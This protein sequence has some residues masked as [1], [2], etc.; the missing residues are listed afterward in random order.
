MGLRELLRRNAPRAALALLLLAGTAEATPPCHAIAEPMG[1]YNMRLPGPGSV[2]MTTTVNLKRSMELAGQHMLG[3]LCPTRNYLPYWS[4][5]IDGNYRAQLWDYW[6]N[7]NLGRW[8]DA[9]LR[10]EDATG[11]SIPAH[12][13]KAMLDNLRLF[14]ENPDHFCLCPLDMKQYKDSF[15][16]LHSL[17]E[18]LLALTALVRYRKSEWAK[19]K[20]HSMIETLLRVTREDGSLCMEKIDRAVRTNNEGATYPIG[21]SL[22]R[23]VEALVWFHK[24]TGD[25]LALLAAR[26]FARYHLDHATHSDGTL[27]R[28]TTGG[29]THSYLGTIRGLLLYGELT[30]QRRYVDRVAATYVTTVRSLVKKSGYTSHDLGRERRGETASPGDAAQLALWLATRHGYTEFYDDVERIVRARIIPSQIT[31]S[32]PLRP[33]ADNDEDENRNLTERVIGA[34]GGMHGAPHWGKRPVLDVTTADLHTLAD[35]YNNIA[36]R[37]DTGLRINFHFDYE[38]DNVRVASERGK[39]ARVTIVPK[40]E[41]N[42]FVRIPGWAPRRSVRLSLNGKPAKLIMVGVFAVVSGELRDGSI[43]VKYELPVSTETER[44]ND[45]D[46]K[47]VWRGDEVIGIRPNSEFYPFYPTYVSAEK[48]K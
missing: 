12:I 29:H 48:A 18:G 15:F 39:S 11:F 23:L 32:P 38:D 28:E 2:E 33:K 41:G 4:M 6:A 26:R 1:M 16:D 8:W 5:R 13:E 22:G 19:D 9:M 44:T 10:L 31:E 46:Y 34:Y 3:F 36:V 42:V 25:P 21:R 47:I 30:G 7:H 14:F 43:V 24:A 40:V 20:G 45:V 37:G 27:N 35:I 17:R